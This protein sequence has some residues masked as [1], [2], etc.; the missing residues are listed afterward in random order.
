MYA[1]QR[2]KDTFPN[3]NYLTLNYQYLDNLRTVKD[4]YNKPDNNLIS[5]MKSY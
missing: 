5:D 1:H 3:I 4:Y 2:Q